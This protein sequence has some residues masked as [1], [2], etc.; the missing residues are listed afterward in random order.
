MESEGWDSDFD[1]VE[2]K[3]RASMDKVKA[4]NR[5]DTSDVADILR[6]ARGTGGHESNSNQKLPDLFGE[7]EDVP[8]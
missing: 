4:A 1:T 6:Y 3:I 7:Q 8:P 2:Q 5:I